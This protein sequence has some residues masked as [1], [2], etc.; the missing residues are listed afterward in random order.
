MAARAITERQR[1]QGTAAE[2]ATAL[3]GC[4]VGCEYF[5]EDTGLL[6]IKIFNGGTGAWQAV[7]LLAAGDSI[8]GRVKIT[9]GTDV[10]LVDNNGNLSGTRSIKNYTG[11]ISATTDI[12]AAV[13]SK[14]IKV[15]AYALFTT[16]TTAVTAK[17]QNDATND[18][19]TVPLQA[20][21]ANS[22]FGANL[23]ISPPDYL[24]ATAAGKKLTLN[25]STGQAVIVSI[26]Y[27]D[28]DA[29]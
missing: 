24:F 7:E 29:T 15:F 2:K 8:L 12:V 10:A 4:A 1:F 26:S 28:D 14:M 25:L 17:F 16:S 21:A 22:F 20:P 13:T 11:S 18:R 6:Y 3:A 23:S 27:W 9:D 5:E 19:W